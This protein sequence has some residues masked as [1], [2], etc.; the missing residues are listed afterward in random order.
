LQVIKKNI[1]WLDDLEAK[2][3]SGQI[4]KKNFLSSSTAEGLRVT[5]TSTLELI[6]YLESSCDFKYV[7]TGKLNQDKLQVGM[8]KYH[9]F[10]S[11]RL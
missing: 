3:Q 8:T 11:I 6:T 5:M 4:E 2:V 1:K 10:E 9:S 7:L